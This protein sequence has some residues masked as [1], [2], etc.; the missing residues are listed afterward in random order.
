M[1]TNL[2]CDSCQAELQGGDPFCLN[3]GK[4][5]PNTLAS[6]NMAIE[7]A[8]VPAAELRKKILQEFKKWFPA[9]DP[10]SAEGKL[11]KNPCVLI[12]GIDDQSA[13]RL[14]A[15][16]KSM[17]ID[18]RL[19]RGTGGS[20]WL[21][22]FWNPGLLIAAGLITLAALV[23][24]LIGLITFVLGVASPILWA[25]WKGNRQRPLLGTTAIN[26]E[27]ARWI[28]VSDQYSR[29]ITKLAIQDAELLRSV[30]RLIIDL[31]KSLK[32][33]SL[34]S[35]AAGE[36][37]GDLYTTLNN[38]SVTA[39]DL[40]RRISSSQGQEKDKLRRELQDL[41]DVISKSHQQFTKLD[42]EEI[43]SV[44]KLT[45][46]INRN[47]ESIDRIVQDIRSPL[48]PTNLESGKI[49]SQ[50]GTYNIPVKEHE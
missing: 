49:S 34:A 17:K 30:M 10:I 4:I 16:L 12:S 37:R 2:I 48:V 5:A 24:G 23:Q 9:L 20:S 38:S 42:R 50:D 27:A 41:I 1:A 26:S 43:K 21:Q 8:D 36:E 19:V 7:I 32:S 6:G 13:K 11:Q 25:F 18:G 33:R 31:Q 39:I 15:I 29:T 14:L 22:L 47:I 44:E 40:C 28:N 46:D 3:C 45:R 35:V